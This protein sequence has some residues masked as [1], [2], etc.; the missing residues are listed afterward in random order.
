MIALAIVLYMLGM[1]P[2]YEVFD[3][4]TEQPTFNKI[5][6]TLFWPVVSIATGVSLIVKL[7][8]KK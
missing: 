1:V 5:W 3:K 4:T 2:T 7:F 8:K 6:F